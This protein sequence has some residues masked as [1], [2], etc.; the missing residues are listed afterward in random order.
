MPLTTPQTAVI[1]P[2]DLHPTRLSFIEELYESLC[3]QE[4]V[5]WEWIVAPNGP[6]AEPD[7]IPRA[8]TRDPRVKVIARPEPGP[9]PARNT[10]LNYVEAPRCT[11]ADDDDQ[12]AAPFSLAVRNERAIIT[13]LGWVAGRSADWDPESGSL[14]TWMSPTPVGRSRPARCWTTGR[15]RSPASHRWDTAC[16]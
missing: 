14:S 15:T 2:T 3:A 9:A 5:T 11:F 1:T 12:L 7:R 4:G 16:C 6:R 8:I 13:G 10:A